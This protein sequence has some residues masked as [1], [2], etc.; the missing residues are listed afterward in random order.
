MLYK[1]STLKICWE[2][3]WKS[4]V[5]EPLFRN[6]VDIIPAILLR[7][8]FFTHVF[9]EI[10]WSNLK[11]LFYLT[12]NLVLKSWWNTKAKEKSDLINNFLNQKNKMHPDSN[13]EPFSSP[14]SQFGQMV[15]RLRTKWFWVWVQLQS[16]KLQILRLLRARSS[17]TFRQQ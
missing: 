12:S 3:P 11:L 6:D 4:T 13:P 15:V 2:I 5:I 10:Q 14:L 17:L 7:K 9:E 8:D 1:V 16:L